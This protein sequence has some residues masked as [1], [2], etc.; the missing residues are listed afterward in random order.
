MRVRMKLFISSRLLAVLMLAAFLLSQTSPANSRPVIVLSYSGPITPIGAEYVSRGFKEAASRGA[1]AVIL[2]LDTPGGLDTAMRKIIREEMNS[3]VPV[4]VF[5]APRG[6]RA[7]SAGCLIVLGADIAAMAP[8]T[9]IGAAHPIT[10][11]G[12]P[13]IEKIVNDAAAYARSLALAHHRDPD[14]A[15]RA[16]RESVSVPET[17][18]LRLGVIDLEANDIPDLLAKLDGHSAHTAAGDAPLALAGA[19]TLPLEMS[20]RE[21]LLEALSDPTVAY[22]LFVLGVLAVVIEIFVPHGMVTG[23]FGLI[24]VLLGLLGVT[25]LPLQVSGV[26]LLIL[27]MVLLGLELKLTSHGLL[28]IAGLVAFIF[29]SLLLVPHIPGYRISLWAI[30]SVTLL[31][32]GMLSIVVR[33]VVKAR[34]RPLLVGTHR[35]VG[36]IGM[37]KTELA[38][39]GVVLVN[40]EDWDALADQPPIARGEKVE[41]IEVQGLT[42]R[43]RKRA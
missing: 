35:V 16:V 15:E 40:G 5:V 13:V 10:A 28:T 41:V 12:G 25:N 19:Q 43:V 2:E 14:W 23:T 4:I 24:A 8:G 17:E 36:S 18:A 22:I 39:R 20:W 37:A 3:R 26:A 6:A 7:A 32:A 29:G 31:W 30:T 1:A 21:R 33:L 34:R 11:S 27:G 38:P 42:V 9:N